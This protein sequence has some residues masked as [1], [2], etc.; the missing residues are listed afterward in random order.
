MY[1]LVVRTALGLSRKKCSSCPG[2]PNSSPD[3]KELQVK[4]WMFLPVRGREVKPS[5]F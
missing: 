1:I 3:V 2:L 5:A 4:P